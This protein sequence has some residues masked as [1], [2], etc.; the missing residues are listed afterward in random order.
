MAL[1]V[2]LLGVLA[3]SIQPVQGHGLSQSLQ[4]LRESESVGIVEGKLYTVGD[5]TT[6]LGMRSARYRSGRSMIYGMEDLLMMARHAKAYRDL[7]AEA[8]GAG[9]V[10]NDRELD[11]IESET[12]SF[13]R[14][15]VIRREILDKVVP[16]TVGD[17]REIYEEIKEEKLATPERII[18]RRVTIPVTDEQGASEAMRVL[19][20][21]GEEVAAGGEVTRLARALGLEAPSRVLYPAQEPDLE[22]MDALRG[23]EDGD[24][25]APRRV[26]GVVEL[27]VRQMLIPADTIPFESSVEM[28]LQIH[29]DRE[30]Q[31]LSHEFFAQL[32]EEPGVL[33]LVPENLQSQGELALDSDVVVIVADNRMT[34]GDLREALGWMVSAASRGDLEEFR[35]RLLDS[36]AVQE[37]LLDHHLDTQGWMESAEVQTYARDLTDT[38]L[39][40]RMLTEPATALMAPTVDEEVLEHWRDKEAS[41]GRFHGRVRY[42]QVGLPAGVEGLADWQAKLA[43]VSS[44]EEFAQVSREIA[45]AVPSA[46]LMSGLQG[47]VS[48]LPPEVG[49]R[50]AAGLVP[51]VVVTTP[52]ENEPLVALWITEGTADRQPTTEE[53]DQSRREVEEMRLQDAIEQVLDGMS[54]QLEMEVLVPRTY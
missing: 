42:D 31:R 29:H 18:L 30:A 17:L 24:A 46:I 54:E 22:L 26:E 15:L 52:V 44:A 10:P 16:P 32:A 50:L 8:E 25:L 14:R 45:S 48:T 12:R 1:G 23:L 11:W 36:G 49:G 40:R 51:G 5:L 35:N 19:T 43:A 38:L 53:R 9:V 2:A 39:A 4:R 7:A 34:R 27:L 3:L 21:L 47:H 33:S 13:A 37:A 28:L 20:D 41:L 6:L